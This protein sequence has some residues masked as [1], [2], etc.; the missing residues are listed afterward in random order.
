[1][2]TATITA[3][4]AGN[5]NYNAAIAVSQPQVITKAN[6]TIAFGVLSSHPYSLNG[7]ID[8]TAT[9]DSGLSVSYSSDNPNIVQVSGNKL[10]I[11]GVG[12]ATITASQAGN[13]NY[14]AAIAAV[15]RTINIIAVSITASFIPGKQIATIV[16][17]FFPL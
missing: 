2:G 5:D 15:S 6:Q 3:S 1:V 9:C 14:N 11:K 4:Q 10:I 17:N 8:L 12:T 7:E 16:F 13:D